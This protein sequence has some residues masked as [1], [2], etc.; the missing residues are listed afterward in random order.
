MSKIIPITGFCTVPDEIT[1]EEFN[2]WLQFEIGNNGDI[3]AD[4]P[5]LGIDKADILN[6]IAIDD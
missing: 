4:N 6:Y 1:D 5:L 3:P 2:D